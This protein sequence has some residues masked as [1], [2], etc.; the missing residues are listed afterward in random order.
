MLYRFSKM[1]KK[2]WPKCRMTSLKNSEIDHKSTKFG[3]VWMYVPCIRESNL[4]NKIQLFFIKYALYSYI[5]IILRT[6]WR[7]QLTVD[8]HRYAWCS[9]SPLNNSS[10]KNESVI[11]E[12]FSFFL[13]LLIKKTLKRLVYPS[14]LYTKKEF[15]Q[16]LHYN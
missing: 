16:I 8:G 5:H 6:G 10:V 11:V 1:L 15:N 9:F 3:H 12:Y 14:F 2:N 7:S 4:A 13:N